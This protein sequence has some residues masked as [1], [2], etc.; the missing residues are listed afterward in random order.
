MERLTEKF[1]IDPD[2]GCWVWGAASD[3]KYGVISLNGRL[4]KAHRLSYML[5]VGEIPEGLDLDHLCRVTRCVNPAHLEP[6]TRSENLRRGTGGG[7]AQRERTHCIHGHPLSGENLYVTPD[8]RRQC[9][10]CGRE[11]DRRY[12][13]AA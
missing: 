2:T 5:H 1:E 6:V 13:H 8:G 7:K 10:T 9:R 3:G 4:V 11:R 12:R